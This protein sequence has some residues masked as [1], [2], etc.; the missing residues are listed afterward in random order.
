MFGE[1]FCIIYVALRYEKK[2]G[3]DENTAIP[4]CMMATKFKGEGDPTG[5]NTLKHWIS[6][7][8]IQEHPQL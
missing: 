3:R 2:F 1:A 4:R 8:Q 7:G 6:A 5:E